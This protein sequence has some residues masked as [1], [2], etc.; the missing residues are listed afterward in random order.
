MFPDNIDVIICEY[1]DLE[2]EIYLE[3]VDKWEQLRY[4]YTIYANYGI[5]IEHSKVR[6]LQIYNDTDYLKYKNLYHIYI[7]YYYTV[8]PSAI[9]TWKFP[10]S[11]KKISVSKKTYKF[12]IDILKTI[13]IKNNIELLLT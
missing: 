5:Y 8:S 3:Y 12:E 6:Y 4:M 11:V 1:L 10:S 7:Y 13:C 2:C 9:N